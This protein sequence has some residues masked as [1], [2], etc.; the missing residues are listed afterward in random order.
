MCVQ[1][2]EHREQGRAT[3][4]GGGKSQGRDTKTNTQFIINP[5]KSNKRL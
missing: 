4:F 1:A 2:A 5:V 3:G